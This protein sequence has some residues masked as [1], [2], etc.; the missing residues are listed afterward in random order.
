MSVLEL[1]CHF[2]CTCTEGLCRI[3]MC[4]CLTIRA[5]KSVQLHQLNN[6]TTTLVVYCDH[7][8]FLAHQS[9]GIQLFPPTV[10][11]PVLLFHQDGPR[12]PMTPNVTVL[13]FFS[14]LH[15]IYI[16]FFYSIRMGREA[17]S[18]QRHCFDFPSASL[19]LRKRYLIPQVQAKT[20][21]I[22]R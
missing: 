21:I 18:T 12:G 16:L 19:M 10:Y 7:P 5:Q 13:I 14:H 22:G 1:D 17:P 4:H 15:C 3:K 6:T 9:A 2:V 8:P 20:D 11:N